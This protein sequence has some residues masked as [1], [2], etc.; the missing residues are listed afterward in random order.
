MTFKIIISKEAELH[1]ERLKKDSKNDYIK[2]FDLVRA[3]L[4]NPRFGIG[5]PERLKHYPDLEV[6]SREINKKD[7][8]VYVINE[9]YATIS[10]E[11]CLG[12]Y[13]DK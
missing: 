1:L 11:S 10:I 12:H 4:L 6:W 9:E 8:L 5:K 3:I 2:C 13:R 7:R